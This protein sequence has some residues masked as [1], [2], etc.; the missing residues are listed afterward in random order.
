MIKKSKLIISMRI[1]Y[2]IGWIDILTGVSEIISAAG[3]DPL[4][5]KGLAGGTL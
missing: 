1:Y 2:S 4:Q 3:R 5:N